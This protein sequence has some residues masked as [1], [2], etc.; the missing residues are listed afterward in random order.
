MFQVQFGLFKDAQFM[1]FNV[2]ERRDLEYF[3]IIYM[4]FVSFMF[5]FVIFKP[6]EK[7]NSTLL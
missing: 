4:D 7:V 6:G 3:S 2:K 1:L 5:K